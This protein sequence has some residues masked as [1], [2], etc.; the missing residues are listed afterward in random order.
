MGTQ[1][2]PLMKSEALTAALKSAS[3]RE[4]FVKLE[5]LQPAGR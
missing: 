4:V 2:T 1:V 5:N 3:G